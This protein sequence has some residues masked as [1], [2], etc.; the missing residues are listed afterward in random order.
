[1]IEQQ[2]LITEALQARNHAYASYSHFR[3]GAALKGISGAIYTGCNI[4]NASYSLT[5]CAERVAIFNAV[6]AGETAFTVMA[7]I[8]DTEQVVS[9]CG[10]C[11]QV[12]AEFFSDDVKIHLCNTD[13]RV[14][15]TTVSELLPAHFKF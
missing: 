4:E 14:Q 15:T 2:Q 9:P 12:M 13:G 7:V 6:S 5:C 1:M 10:A 3:V 8:A 11:R